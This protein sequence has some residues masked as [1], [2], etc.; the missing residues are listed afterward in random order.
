MFVLNSVWCP[1]ARTNELCA[2]PAPHAEAPRTIS[3][4][5][6]HACALGLHPTKVNCRARTMNWNHA[7]ARSCE[8]RPIHYATT[9]LQPNNVTCLCDS[10]GADNFRGWY[11]HPRAFFGWPNLLFAVCQPSPGLQSC[12]RGEILVEAVRNPFTRVKDTIRES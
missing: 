9:A 1:G 10:R 5:V 8:N 7:H 11:L 6:K 3:H 2:A 4:R 12:E